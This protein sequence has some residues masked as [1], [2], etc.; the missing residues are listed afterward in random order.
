MHVQATPAVN[1]DNFPVL[2]PWTHTDTPHCVIEVNQNCNI[3][4][5]GCFKDKA[6]YHKSLELIKSEIDLIA[7][8]RN[9]DTITIAGG[10]PLLFE[11]LAEVVRYIVSKNLHA[12][13]LTNGTLLTVAKIVELKKAG[14]AHIMIHLDGHQPNRP[15][16]TGSLN[17]KAL[18]E[19]RKKYIALGKEG[20]IAIDFCMT[21]Y[22][23]TLRELPDVLD[24]FHSEKRIQAA[25]FTCYAQWM[26]LHLN[27]KERATASELEVSDHDIIN[28]MARYAHIYPAYYIPRNT[29]K[30]KLSL[31][32]YI[33]FITNNAR[34][35]AST[36][37]ITPKH[38]FFLT[39]SL[40]V[41]RALAGRYEFDRRTSAC[42]AACMLMA[43]G[44]MSFRLTTLWA[45]IRLLFKAMANHNLRLY[46]MNFQILPRRIS[47]HEFERCQVCP[48]I[49]VR[50][51]KIIPYC[52]AD[53][54]EP[55]ID[56]PDLKRT[57]D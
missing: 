48:D 55:I 28:A 29:D 10:E 6:H 42:D 4:C 5:Y 26:N 50:N 15:D 53:I 35:E 36:L 49:T 52:T 44:L 38:R 46:T 51:G 32:Y 56:K 17:E 43:Y 54:V 13:L 9:L 30:T 37:Y 3:K 57:S 23:D 45:C 27:D 31:F 33:A 2:L 19:L 40:K 14:L 12:M 8:E 16:V 20:D 11:E 1:A 39:S 25:I 21:I 18:N 22:R 47:E 34:G 24:Y 7:R 41:Y